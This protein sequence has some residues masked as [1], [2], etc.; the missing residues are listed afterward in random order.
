MNRY[1][2]T[3]PAAIARS[4]TIRQ[5]AIIAAII[6]IIVLVLAVAATV[7]ITVAVVDK[8]QRDRQ[9]ASFIPTPIASK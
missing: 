9:N 6:G 5:V 8:K 2:L 7:G 3:S 1:K 4:V